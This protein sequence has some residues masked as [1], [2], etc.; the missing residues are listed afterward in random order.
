MD[1]T[2]YVSHTF[3]TDLGQRRGAWYRSAA[4]MT[5]IHGLGLICDIL[6][7]NRC[8]T[9]RMFLWS[10]LLWENTHSLSSLPSSGRSLVQQR[11]FSFLTARQVSFFTAACGMG[12]FSPSPSCQIELV[13]DTVFLLG[14]ELLLGTSILI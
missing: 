4:A 10:G 6:N 14:E 9:L 3:D 5:I 11:Q 7:E 8:S 2:K 1:S 13:L 12:I